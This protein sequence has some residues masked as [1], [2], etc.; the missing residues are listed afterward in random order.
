MTEEERILYIDEQMK[1]KRIVKLGGI[2]RKLMEQRGIKLEQY[3]KE[4]PVG[5]LGRKM[6]S[7]RNNIS[8]EEVRRNY[9]G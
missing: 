3:K 5:N 2:I 7:F 4:N 6:P 8:I 9:N 1:F